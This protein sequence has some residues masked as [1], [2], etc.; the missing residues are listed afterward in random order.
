MSVV[1]SIDGPHLG[2]EGTRPADIVARGQTVGAPAYLTVSLNDG[3]KG[4]GQ[5]PRVNTRAEQSSDCIRSVP[6]SYLRQRLVA[7]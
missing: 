6:L 3:V 4:G 2:I 1:L 5:R 7:V